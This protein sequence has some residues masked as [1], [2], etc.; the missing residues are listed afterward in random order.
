MEIP[1]V[2]VLISVMLILMIFVLPWIEWK[3]CCI[4]SPSLPTVITEVIKTPKDDQLS[5]TPSYSEFAP[6]DYDRAMQLS[7]NVPA[8]GNPNAQ[9]VFV[10]DIP[11]D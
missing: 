11:K 5:P 7:C 2:Y 4:E 9:S 3:L 1:F 8:S 6:P 10:I